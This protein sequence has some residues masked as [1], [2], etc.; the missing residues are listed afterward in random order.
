MRFNVAQLLK[1]PAGASREY[2]LD[3]DITGI[4]E[5]LDVVASLIGRVKFLRTGNGIL[6]TGH[7]QT[8]IRVPCRRC[9]TPVTVLIEVDLEEQF[10]P[11]VD[12][13]T[14]A[15]L[16]LEPGEEEATR[17]DAHHILDL[18]EVVRQ[19]LLINLPMAPLCSPQCKGL[20]PHCGANLNEG[21]CGCQHEEV[22][23][24]LT[25]LRGLL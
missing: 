20:C 15:I 23:P 18:T 17:T 25:I 5:D 2:D 4:D 14:G 16:P 12:I 22:D 10:R 24:R 6:V 11:S 3:E 8:E 1:S 19:N 9:L 13:W 7:I 21:P